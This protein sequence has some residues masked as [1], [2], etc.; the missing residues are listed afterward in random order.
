M[1]FIKQWIRNHK[2]FVNYFLI[3]CTVTVI[4]FALVLICTKVLAH[5]YP[6]PAVICIIPK[7]LEFSMTEIIANTVG[8]V[9]GFT[10]QYILC[11]RKV[12]AGS[13]WKT[14]AAFFGTFLI[15]LALA[16]ILYGGAMEVVFH[17]EKTFF[18]MVVSKGV[19]VVIPYFVMYFLR[20]ALIR[21]RTYE[22]KE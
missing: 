22:E 5:Y 10:I 21:E 16:D 4:D 15:G 19:S 18:P 3:S 6:D 17:G 1:S 11:T 12:Y 8:V 7:F 9:T 20:K 13:D 2:N 14:F